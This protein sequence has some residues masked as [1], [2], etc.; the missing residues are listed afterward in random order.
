MQ[1]PEQSLDH[2]YMQMALS[3][4]KQGEGTTAPNP[5]VGAVIVQN[6]R[7]I[8]KGFHEVCGEAHA[9]VNAFRDA[10]EDVAGATMYV[11][12][13]PCSHY[14][15]TPPC[16]DLIVQKKIKRVVVAMLDP[17]PL[18]AGRGI[19]KLKKA[20][21]QVDVGIMEAESRHLNEVFLK[22]IVEKRPFVLWK[23][24]MTLD[25]KIATVTG[26]SQWISNEISREEVHHLRGIYTG[27][28]VGIGT[29]K[30][31]NPHLTCRTGGKNPIRIVVDSNLQVD[32]TAHVLDGESP[33]I[34][35]TTEGTD[36]E[37]QK[38]LRSRG[39][40]IIETPSQNGHVDLTFLMEQLGKRG[41]DSI[42]LEGGPTLTFSALE[43]NL[44]DKIRFYIAPKL[45]GGATARTPSGGVGI[46]HICDAV[47][48]TNTTVSRCGEDIVVEGYPQ[49]R[50]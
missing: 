30:A 37:K 34:F 10:K 27:I 19:E 42:L 11:T 12:L 50:R 6:N 4:A 21:I 14:G 39:V 16:A 45:L 44:I 3:L 36:M 15:K 49:K 28:M 13:E 40:E 25:G 48:I 43:Q 31:D 47:A 1:T 32:E 17:N 33:T 38:R 35:A 20:G 8:G 9:E 5:M 41:I 18:V 24:A 46:P 26:E 23:T 22:Y 29:V 7:V 2:Q